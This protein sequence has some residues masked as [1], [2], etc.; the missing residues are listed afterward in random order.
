[1]EPIKILIVDD[2]VNVAKAIQ[3]ILDGAGFETYIATSGF[4]A[5]VWLGHIVPNIMTLDLNMPDLN[6]REIIAFIRKIPELS[7]TKILMVSGCSDQDLAE[8][9]QEGADD[10]LQKPFDNNTLIE[11]IL[12]LTAD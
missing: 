6:G 8:T 1:M 9:I 3:R 11:K 10:T 12:K 2:E 5:G 4:E 7:K